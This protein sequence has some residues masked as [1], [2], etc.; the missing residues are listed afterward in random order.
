MKCD[1]EV[2]RPATF[3]FV[4]PCK[5]D[6]KLFKG[7]PQFDRGDLTISESTHLPPA[8]M[9]DNRFYTN[10]ANERFVMPQCADFRPRMQ[11]ET[12]HP[13]NYETDLMSVQ[14]PAASK[15]PPTQNVKGQTL[16]S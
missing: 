8:N 15:R 3:E 12:V 5:L 10:Y 2:L 11:T 4:E 16:L 9:V 14:T 6:K 13:Y 1:G 7:V